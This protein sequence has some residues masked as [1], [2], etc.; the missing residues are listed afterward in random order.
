MVVNLESEQLWRKEEMEWWES[1]API[2][3]YQWKLTPALNKVLRQELVND[4]TQFLL[5]PNGR[6]LDLGCGSGWLS[7]FFAEKGMSVLGIDFSQ[8]QIDAAEK[9]KSERGIEAIHFECCDLVHWNC[10]QERETFDSVFVN[11]F[12]HHL[13]SN[14]IEA[15]MSKIA[16]VLKPRGRVYLYEPMTTFLQSKALTLKSIEYVLNKVI[17]LAVG[18]FPRWL[19][20]WSLHF[21]KEIEKGYNGCSPHE[22]P[23]DI[24]WLKTNCLKS[25]DLV[26]VK[27]WHLYSLSFAMQAMVIKPGIRFVYFWLARLLYYIDRTILS[28]VDWKKFTSGNRFI[29]CSLKL[30]K[31][32]DD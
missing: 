32:Y 7:F 23:L 5:K 21:Q 17:G 16:T 30:E 19:K 18:K 10:I 12:L 15:I 28:K 11:A 31:K 24:E 29:L 26:E 8:E 6:L 4:Y 9:Q 25:L 1:F 13:P 22:R 14:D 20:L 2:M 27:C 3:T